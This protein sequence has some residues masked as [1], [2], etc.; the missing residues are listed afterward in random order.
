MSHDSGSEEYCVVEGHR[1]QLC[2][3]CGQ[4]I[5]LGVKGDEYSF[6]VHKGSK[7]CKGKQ[8]SNDRKKAAEA[9]QRLF[10]NL[11]TRLT[12]RLHRNGEMNIANTQWDLVKLGVVF[13][14]RLSS[15]PNTPNPD[16]F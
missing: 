11:A 7:S 8:L 3:D 13:V 14:S 15:I 1:E 9:R 4:W 12:N 2:L 16:L 5:G 6:H 10:S